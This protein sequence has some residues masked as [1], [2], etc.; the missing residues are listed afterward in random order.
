MRTLNAIEAP[1]VIEIVQEIL[2]WSTVLTALAIAG[3]WEFVKKFFGQLGAR[4][5]DGVAAIA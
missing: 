4:S 2:S 5:G 3:G 1:L